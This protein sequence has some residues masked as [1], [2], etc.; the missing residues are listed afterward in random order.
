[1]PETIF[2]LQTTEYD[3][4]GSGVWT[5]CI[6]KVNGNSSAARQLESAVIASSI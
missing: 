4:Q 5:L 1:M 2:I 6:W 3:A